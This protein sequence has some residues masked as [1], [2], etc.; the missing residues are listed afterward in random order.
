MNERV[1]DLRS[2]TVTRPSPGM[3]QAMAEAEVDDDVLGKDPTADRLERRV[4]KLLGKD[5]AL[6][7]PSGTQANQA[8]VILHTRPGT[9]AVCESESHVFHY[10]YADAAWLAG[11]QLFPVASERGALTAMDVASAVRPDDR[12]HPVTSLVC[13]EN[14]HNMHGGSVIP[15]PAMQAIQGL[16][17]EKSLPVH[18]DGARLWNA[19]AAAGV[20]LTDFASCAD[21]VTVCLSKGM[22]CPIG[23][24][25]AGPAE[26][27]SNAWSVRKRL[28]GGMRQVGILAAAG[29]WA[30]DHNLGRL[31]EDH[32]RARWLARDCDA[33]E[34]IRADA[35]DTNIVMIHLEREDLDEETVAADLGA[36]GIWVLPAGTRRLRAVTHLD[37][38]DEGIERSLHALAHVLA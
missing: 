22:G 10:E 30:L 35:P 13:V 20:A 1:V 4:A 7:F 15:V 2:D 5:A 16:A 14:T 36:R 19:A 26:L 28:G 31:G 38:D 18:L 21:T 11:V 17:R 32:A 29:L 34:G 23:S 25:L 33:M 27:I 37:I 6:F 3:R 12:H 24:L 8:A 9:E